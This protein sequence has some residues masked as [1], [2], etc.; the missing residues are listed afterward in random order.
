[1]GLGRLAICGMMTLGPPCVSVAGLLDLSLALTSHG[2]R[3]SF[4]ENDSSK[5]AEHDQSQNK[6]SGAVAPSILPISDCADGRTGTQDVE[7]GACV[8]QYS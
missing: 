6:Q 1:M 2:F 4:G 3:R 5:E 8:W 7:E